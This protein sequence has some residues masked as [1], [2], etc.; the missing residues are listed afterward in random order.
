MHVASSGVLVSG[1]N[2]LWK[3]DEALFRAWLAVI[4]ATA[5]PAGGEAEEVEEEKTAAAAAEEEAEVVPS[6]YF[7][8]RRCVCGCLSLP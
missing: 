7:F 4:N 1:F 8:F 5:A 3:I 2:Q 6:V